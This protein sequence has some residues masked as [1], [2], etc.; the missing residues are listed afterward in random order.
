MKQINVRV[1]NKKNK[2]QPVWYIVV[3]VVIFSLLFTSVICIYER[4]I[5]VL[6]KESYDIG[7]EAG[8]KVGSKEKW[9]SFLDGYNRGRNEFHG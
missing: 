4:K 6:E 5:E 8:Y 7:Y 1:K 9:S 3:I 2:K